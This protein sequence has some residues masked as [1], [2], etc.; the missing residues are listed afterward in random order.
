MPSLRGKVEQTLRQLAQD[1]FHP[2]LHSHKLKGPLYAATTPWPFDKFILSKV[3]GAQDRSQATGRGVRRAGEI[4]TR[5]RGDKG[6]G[7]RDGGLPGGGVAG[8]REAG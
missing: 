2:S 8:E 4:G 5:E 7:R 1:P 3:E 6:T